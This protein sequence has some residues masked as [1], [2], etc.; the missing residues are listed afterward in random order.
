VPSK[1]VLGGSGRL[2][3][4]TDV[5]VV[6]AGMDGLR[7]SAGPTLRALLA[8]ASASVAVG[9]AAAL[10]RDGGETGG[11]ETATAAAVDGVAMTAGCF[12]AG[13]SHS[14][15]PPPSSNPAPKLSK[16]ERRS[17]LGPPSG[18]TSP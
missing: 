16:A 13:R 2:G 10:G 3:L 14:K 5:D 12:G 15:A 4:D 9:A 1:L 8:G 17:G 6:G 7:S 18:T 11:V